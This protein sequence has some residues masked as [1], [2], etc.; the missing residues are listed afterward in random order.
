MQ[1][2]IAVA[3]IAATAL[4]ACGD[5]D[6][7]VTESDV[8]SAVDDAGAAVTDVA[9]ELDATATDMETTLRDNGLDSLA[10][11]V[12]QVDLTEVLGTETF[13]FFAPNDDAFTTLTAEQTADLLTD[14]SQIVET[15]RNHT[16]DT[17][18]TAGDLTSSE[19]VS[20]RAGE[21]L[22]VTVDGDTVMVGDVTVVTTD[23]EVGDGVIH[24][25]D[26]FLI[27]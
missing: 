22:D 1:R 13:T 7:A 11:I 10:G 12:E 17:T 9:E 2:F 4:A 15:L 5:D 23:I 6:D 26:G 20:T 19:Q 27:P 14:P 16:L 21:T 18:V 25:V 3:L 24:V 8:E